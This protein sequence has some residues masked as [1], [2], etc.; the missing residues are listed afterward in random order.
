[1]TKLRVVRWRQGL[2]LLAAVIAVTVLAGMTWTVVAVRNMAPRAGANDFI[3]L[4]TGHDQGWVA[5]KVRR[6]ERINLLLLARGGA[7]DDNPDFT[8]TV[9]LLSIRPGTHRATII[10]LPRWLLVEIP[11]APDGSSVQGKLYTA[12]A[13]GT[14]GNQEFLQPRWRTP[15][16]PGDL[17]AATVSATV[18]QPIDGWVSIDI[19]GFAALIDAVGGVTV[20]VPETLDD[21]R[22][23]SDENHAVIHVHFEPGTQT[24]DGRHALQYARSRRSTSDAERSRRQELILSALLR[25]LRTANVSPALIPALGPLKDGLRTDLLPVDVRLLTAV[26][27]GVKEQDIKRI[28]L[29]NSQLLKTQIVLGDQPV[30]VPASGSWNEIQAYV[31]SELP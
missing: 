28:T 13:L 11:A 15:T 29:E 3:E 26:L 6:D 21:T 19:A 9:L 18:G 4:V 24:L 30:L 8:D 14:S 5:E 12:Y 25:R 7:G 20:N 22:Y 10:S 2:R 16:G 17:A 1:M 31:A 27:A 23:P